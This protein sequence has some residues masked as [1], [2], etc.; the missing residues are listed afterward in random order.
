MQ[1]ECSAFILSGYFAACISLIAIRLIST[2]PVFAQ[3][4]NLL[5]A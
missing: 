5:I 3:P 4:R 1:K 2:L